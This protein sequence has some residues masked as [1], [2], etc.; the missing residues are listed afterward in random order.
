[1]ASADDP[2]SRLSVCAR[3]P[4]WRDHADPAARRLTAQGHAI[5]GGLGAD[6]SDA[7]AVVDRPIEA[8]VGLLSQQESHPARRRSLHGVIPDEGVGLVRGDVLVR[9]NGE[10]PPLPL[11]A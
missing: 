7:Q 9:G 3:E 8:L 4:V 10:T 6:R 2:R 5:G 1:M 11:I